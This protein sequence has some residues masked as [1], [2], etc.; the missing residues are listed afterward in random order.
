ML[1]G[2]R[3]KPWTCP[4]CLRTEQ[5]RSKRFFATAAAAVADFKPT[6]HAIPGAEKDDSVLRKVF[7]SHAFWKEFS[8]QAQHQYSGKSVGLFQNRY[9]TRPE[10]FQ[11]FA[12]TTLYKCRKIVGRVLAYK[13]AEEYKSIAQDL[14][15][16][17][18]LLCRVIDLSD[19]VRAT[20]PDRRVQAAATQAYALMFE[21]MNVLNTTTGLNEQLK[22]AAAIPEVVSGWNEEEK[23]VANILIKDFSKSAIDLAE[24]DRQKF[25]DLSN[26]ISQVGPEFVDNMAAETP[27]LSFESSRLKGMDPIVVR[28]LTRWGSVTLPSTGVPAMI[29]LRTVENADAR[30]E[31]YVANRTSSKQNIQRLER[32]LKSRAELAQLS[33]Y[34]SFSHMA[35]SDKMAQTPEAVTQ[36]L[37]ALAKDNAPLVASELAELFEL[38]QADARSF[39]FPR[40]LNAWDR[41]YYT[42][43]LVSSLRSRA[44]APDFLSAY[45]SLGTVMQGLSRLFYRLYG[46]RLVPRETVPGETWNSDVRRLDVLDDADGHIAVIYCDLFERVG[47]N[48][49]PAHFTLRCSRR[50]SDGE[51]QEAAILS[52]ANPSLFPTARDAVNDGLATAP[53]ANDTRYPNALYQLPTIALICDFALPPTST[54][55]SKPRP[56]LLTFREVQTL[57]H[58]MGHALHSIC[59]R[60]SL[61][62]VSGTRCATD[63]AELP[64]VLMEH[65]AS[66]PDVLALYARHWE[67]DVPLDLGRIKECLE[68]D[69]RG[70][71]AEVE[72]QVLLAMLDQSYHSALPRSSA[73]D[74]TRTYHDIYSQYSA[75][76]EPAGTSWQGFFGHLFGY[77][78]TYYSYLFDRAIAQKVW[79]EVFAGG[80]SSI[81][82]DAGEQ[83]KKEVL[84]WGGG[85]D[86][87]RCVAGVLGRQ[88]EALGEGGEEAMAEVGRWG[89]GR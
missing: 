42:A 20:H 78:A 19:F 15:R 49:N 25:V 29:A 75:V 88:G 61:Q 82:R 4:Q 33:G 72:S 14:D 53:N 1:K 63:F 7:D 69:K 10:G 17:S 83:Y 18:D 86:G 55:A 36:F 2:L 65:F 50:I 34:E 73:F 80:K 11:E 56:T 38:K 89:V 76:P 5:K 9:L 46:I 85:R 59:G 6:N 62:N 67:T 87:W 52:S 51:M 32:L 70:A 24:G 12:S 45:F 23:T 48:P 64:S 28:Q 54:S 26:E 71:G 37:K 27:Y 3:K 13:T 74:S 60:T 22:N 31:I 40:E 81:D 21:Y 41:D 68:I 35:L 43:R 79:K 66:A 44:R 47:K 57:F 39:N 84:R 30:R 16:L 58:E 77:G 8:A